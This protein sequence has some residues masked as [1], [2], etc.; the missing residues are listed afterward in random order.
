MAEQYCGSC[1]HIHKAPLHE[2]CKKKRK[3]STRATTETAVETESVDGRPVIKPE[4]AEPALEPLSEVSEDE[5]RI[6]AER[7]QALEHHRRV[8]ELLLRER[9][10]EEE[11]DKLVLD[12]DAQQPRGRTLSRGAGRHCH[13]HHRSSSSTSSDRTASREYWKRHKWSI[14][15]ITE[16]KEIKK[17]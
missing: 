15:K 1:G 8:T 7:V 10:L 13:R 11:L 16:E 9:R 3:R 12:S 6:V 5:E 14:R 4:P 2:L 17:T